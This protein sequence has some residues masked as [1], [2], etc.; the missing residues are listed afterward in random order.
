MLP[1]KRGVPETDRMGEAS[2]LAEEEVAIVGVVGRDKYL[3]ATE[4]V[5]LRSLATLR[6]RVRGRQW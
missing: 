1:D 5:C 6:Q 3:E 2:A 4:V